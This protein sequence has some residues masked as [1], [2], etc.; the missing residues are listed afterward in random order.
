MDEELDVS[1]SGDR[2][3]ERG[4]EILAC[5]VFFGHIG[6]GVKG[7][8]SLDEELDDFGAADGDEDR[9]GEVVGWAFLLIIVIEGLEGPE[10]EEEFG[11]FGF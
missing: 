2:D 11:D 8:E 3:E 9:C 4:I 6:E 7:S 10:P 1:G 5:G